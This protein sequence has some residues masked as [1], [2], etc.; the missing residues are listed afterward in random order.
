MTA[1]ARALTLHLV[2]A[3]ESGDALGGALMQA[4]RAQSPGPI[5]F[6]GVGGGAMAAQGINHASRI[7]ACLRRT[8]APPFASR[9]Q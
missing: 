2:A 1:T 7:S 8:V 4:L 5:S 3:E 9:S 6:E